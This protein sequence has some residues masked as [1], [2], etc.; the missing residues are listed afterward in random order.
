MRHPA[1]LGGVAA[2]ARDPGLDG[3]DVVDDHVVIVHARAA[4]RPFA[5]AR[6][7]RSITPQS[8]SRRTRTPHSSITS[9]R[10]ASSMRSPRCERGHPACSTCP[11]DGG[12]PRLTRSTRSP[13]EDHRAHAHAGRVRILARE[14]LIR[15]RS[16]LGERAGAGLV[17]VIARPERVQRSVPYFSRTSA[18]RELH[19]LAPPARPAPA[20]A[21]APRGSP[22]P[23]RSIGLLERRGAGRATASSVV[24]PASGSRSVGNTRRR[25]SGAAPSITDPCWR[26]ADALPPLRAA[27]HLEA[28][29]FQLVRTGPREAERRAS[30]RGRRAA[31]A[32]SRPGRPG[33]LSP[34]ASAAPIHR[35]VSSR[36]PAPWKSPAAGRPRCTSARARAPRGGSRCRRSGRRTS[37]MPSPRLRAASRSMRRSSAWP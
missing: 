3:G 28:G 15:T 37:P 9:R 29:H 31:P 14:R 4:P 34:G 20:R 7:T 2:R 36:S 17:T 12:C 13:V 6:R 27:H 32:P 22:R 26:N 1:H 21:R 19:L 5:G 10:A 25:R 8:P 16:P 18:L 24:M 23:A 33:D 11:G 30:R 35:Y